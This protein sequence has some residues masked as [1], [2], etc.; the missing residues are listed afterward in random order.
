MYASIINYR[1]N[2]SQFI[3]MDIRMFFQ[4]NFLIL[5]LIYQIRFIITF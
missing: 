4:F 1:V 5:N 2:A 3:T